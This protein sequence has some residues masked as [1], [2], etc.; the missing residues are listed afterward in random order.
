[1]E[2]SLLRYPLLRPVDRIVVADNDAVRDDKY[3]V[4]AEDPNPL[5]G[6]IYCCPI[7]VETM[8]APEE[9][10]LSVSTYNEMICRPFD[11]DETYFADYV[12]EEFCKRINLELRL[13]SIRKC[14][15]VEK[16][17][18]IVKEQEI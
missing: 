9:Y 15:E 7:F 1:M 16:V 5:V 11:E 14:A 12:L 17:A 4:V 6:S 18:T 8:A 3:I 2:R 13:H 10:I